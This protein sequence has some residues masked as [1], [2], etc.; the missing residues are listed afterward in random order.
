MPH[1]VPGP[2]DL[3]P[4]Q[5]IDIHAAAEQGLVPFVLGADAEVALSPRFPLE[6]RRLARTRLAVAYATGWGPLA[7][8]LR[9]LAM[10]AA[11]RS[12]DADQEPTEDT[13]DERV[14]RSYFRWQELAR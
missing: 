2:D 13:P 5:I 10:W 11:A 4:E 9:E 3:T 12:F 8:L 7:D 14:V 6:E 1:P